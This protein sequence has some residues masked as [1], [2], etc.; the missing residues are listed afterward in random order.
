[1]GCPNVRTTFSI[2]RVVTSTTC[3]FLVSGRESSLSYNRLTTVASV[4]VGNLMSL[5]A[6][7]K[8]SGGL[9]ESQ[10]FLA[11]ELTTSE[12]ALFQKKKVEAVLEIAM[13]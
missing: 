5:Q 13:H 7:P 12:R 4:G 11:I 10:S 1:M 2:D 3:V 9:G 8:L 6:L